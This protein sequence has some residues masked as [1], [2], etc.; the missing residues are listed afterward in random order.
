MDLDVLFPIERIDAEKNA[1]GQ[2]MELGREKVAVRQ[3]GQIDLGVPIQA[4]MVAPAELNLQTAVFG[5]D[6][7]TGDDTEIDFALF[8]TQILGPLDEDVALDKTHPGKT[9]VV[10]ARA[11]AETRQR[12]DHGRCDCDAPQFFHRISPLAPL[13]CEKRANLPSLKERR[14]GRRSV[15]DF[16]HLGRNRKKS[17]EEI[18]IYSCQKNPPPPTPI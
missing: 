7:I 2:D 1:A 9:A 15:L 5:P 3:I 4:Q 18:R 8:E 14:N 13:Y 17:M 10:I 6:F 11:L 16:G 12:Q